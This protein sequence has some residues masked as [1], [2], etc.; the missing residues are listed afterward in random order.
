MPKRP[1]HIQVLI[2]NGLYYVGDKKSKDVKW[3][4]KEPESKEPR[5]I[6]KDKE[7]LNGNIPAN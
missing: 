6:Q 5:L 3:V 2:D 4:P 1:R 7:H